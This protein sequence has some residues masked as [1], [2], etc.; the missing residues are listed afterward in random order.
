MR[1]V[2][3]EKSKL[4]MDII[5]DILTSENIRYKVEEIKPDIP[6]GVM[7]FHPIPSAYNI[8]IDVSLEKFDFIKKLVNDRAGVLLK[9]EKCYAIQNNMDNVTDYKLKR[10]FED[11]LNYRLKQIFQTN[12]VR[13]SI[14]TIP[15]SQSF[16]F[17]VEEFKPER[18]KRSLLKTIGLW[19]VKKGK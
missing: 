13:P 3:N 9:L 6:M 11:D 19:L 15:T 2:F 5:T 14:Y 10:E 17:T 16:T 8:T 12:V 4:E 7:F 1:F 18:K